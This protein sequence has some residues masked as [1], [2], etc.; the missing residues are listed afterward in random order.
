MNL[1]EGSYVDLFCSI[2]LFIYH[3]YF[4]PLQQSLLGKIRLLA[5]D[6][7]EEAGKSVRDPDSFNFL[8]V[9]DFP[10]FEFDDQLGKIVSVH[11]PFTLPKEGEASLM[12][13]EP[14]KVCSGQVFYGSFKF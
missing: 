11:H 4:I 8:W 5:A 3:L 13:T 2:W 6:A 10:L 9:I 1:F 14:L 12:Y 7:L